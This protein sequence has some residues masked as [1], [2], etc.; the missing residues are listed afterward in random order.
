MH[1]LI[2]NKVIVGPL[3]MTLQTLVQSYSC[4]STMMNCHLQDTLLRVSL[5]LWKQKIMASAGASRTHMARMHNA[6]AAALV[7]HRGAEN[8]KT[9][10]G[11]GLLFSVR[12][13][14]VSAISQVCEPMCLG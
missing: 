4:P 11:I 14:L 9:P 8:V 5:T 10:L 7:M 12:S 3:Q 13:Q 2:A 1:S 6:G